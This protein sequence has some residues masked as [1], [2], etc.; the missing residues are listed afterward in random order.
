[1]K[2]EGIIQRASTAAIFVL[3]MLGGLY[4]GRYSFVLLFAIITGVCL[5]E[6]LGMVL[7]RDQRRDQVRRLIGLGLGLTPFVLSTIVQM[8]WLQNKE[9]FIIISALL[10]SPFIF[11]TFVYEL[12]TGSKEPFSNIANMFMGMI[13]I[14]IPFALLDFIAFDGTYFYAD[15]V[16]GLLLMTWA[17]DSA[18]YLFGSVYGRRKLFP[19]ISPKKT[20]EGSAGGMVVT[21]LI[22]WLLSYFFLELALYHWMALAAIVVVFGTLGDLVESMLKRS[23]AAKDSG[24]LLPGHGGV[25]DRFD[26]FIFLLPFATAYLLWIR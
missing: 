26:G 14:G 25:L 16:F 11:M 5:W 7:E 9:D 17:N 19:R 12:Y 1:M 8:N 2:I 4:G 13:Y 20:W 23:V 15:T 3:V 10:L 21:F 18:A 6:F 22:A 24:S